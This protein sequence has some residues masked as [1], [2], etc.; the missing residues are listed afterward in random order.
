[1]YTTRAKCDKGFI[2][3]SNTDG[4]SYTMDKDKNYGTTPVGLLSS[5]LSGCIAMCVRGYYL[6]KRLPE[7]NIEVVTE[8]EPTN[9]YAKIYIDKDFD[10]KEAQEIIEYVNKV[11]TVSQMLSKDIPL[12]KEVFKM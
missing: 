9:I 8:T 3:N 1:M 12:K 6:R 7:V 4:F 2:V 5:A 10:E 11:C